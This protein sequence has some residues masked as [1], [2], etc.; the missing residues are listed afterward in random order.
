MKRISANKVGL[1]GKITIRL[2]ESDGFGCVSV[3]DN[4]GGIDEEVIDKI[5]EP[6]F[7]TKSMGTGIGLYMSKMIIERSMNGFIEA[8]NIKGGAEFTVSTPLDRRTAGG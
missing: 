6:Y 3:S 4:G 1:A 5:F 7:S 8:H 2:Y